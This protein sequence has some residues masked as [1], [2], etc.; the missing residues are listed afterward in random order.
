MSVLV[1]GLTSYPSIQPNLDQDITTSNFQLQLGSLAF[2]QEQIEIDLNE[3]V[4]I[5]AQEKSE[6]ETEDE[7]TD[8]ASTDATTVDS[9]DVKETEE[10]EIEIEVEEEEAEEEEEFNEERPRGDKTRICH[11]QFV[12]NVN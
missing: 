7:E 10:E 3:E 4:R 9:T 1:L 8:V 6:E 5:S 2:A 11:L 12:S